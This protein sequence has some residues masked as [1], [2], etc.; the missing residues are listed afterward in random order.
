MK[1][2]L[3]LALI[4]YFVSTNMQTKTYE[5]N[6]STVT[7]Y[8]TITEGVKNISVKGCNALKTAVNN[9]DEDD[10]V[11]LKNKVSDGLETL[12]DGVSSL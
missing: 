2:L 5:S 10:I 3:I 12:K 11:N 8:N 6:Q 1:K 4:I 7:W 9:I